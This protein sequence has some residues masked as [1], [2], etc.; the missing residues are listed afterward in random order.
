MSANTG[1]RFLKGIGQRR[2]GLF[3]KLDISN[4]GQLVRYYPRA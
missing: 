2:A 3:E 1:I 4:V